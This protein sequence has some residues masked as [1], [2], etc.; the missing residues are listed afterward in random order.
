MNFS[1]FY[2][3]I[4]L[5]HP[6][7]SG[8]CSQSERLLFGRDT[9]NLRRCFRRFV[10]RNRKSRRREAAGRRN[11]PEA[12]L[13]KGMSRETPSPR[14]GAEILFSRHSAQVVGRAPVICEWS[15]SGVLFVSSREAAKHFSP[16]G[17]ISRL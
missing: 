15:C 4:F 13:Y 6:E 7:A 14:L 16:C 12:V 3:P 17:S 10:G 8:Y 2:Y 5:G 11:Y 9:R 1:P